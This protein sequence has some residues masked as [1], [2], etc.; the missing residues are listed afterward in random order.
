MQKRRQD[1][2]DGEDARAVLE[3]V[4]LVGTDVESAVVV[5]GFGEYLVLPLLQRAY[6]G[7]V[8]VVEGKSGRGDHKGFVLRSLSTAVGGA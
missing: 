2:D 7:F 6:R 3:P 4:D 1:G 8:T 5:T